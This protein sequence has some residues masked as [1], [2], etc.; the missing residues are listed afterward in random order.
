MSK[1]TIPKGT[2]DFCPIEIKERLKIKKIIKDNFKLFGYFP[3]KTPSF[4]RNSIFNKKYNEECNKL[5]FNI[6]NSGN[7]LKGKINKIYNLYKKNQKK[8]NNQNLISFFSKKALRYDLTVPLI[9]Y[10]ITHKN[11]IFFPFKRYQIQPVWRAE[12]PQKGRYR[13][14]YQ[15]DADIIGKKSLFQEIEL[16]Y[17]CDKILKELNFPIIFQINHRIILHFLLNF[18]LKKLNWMEFAL[19]LDKKNKIG[20]KGIKEEMIKKGI[21]KKKINKI[22]FIFFEKKK[23]KKK[24][25]NIYNILSS[26]KK[27]K[28][29]IKEL[30]FFYKNFKK[31]PLKHG[32]IKFNLALARGINYYTGIIFEIFYDLNLSY[33]LGGGGRYDKLIKIFGLKNISGIGISLGLDRIHLIMKKLN[34]FKKITPFHIQ[35][36]FINF[37]KKEAFFSIKIINFFRK[38]NISSELYPNN[39]KIKKQFKYAYKK[40]IPYVIMI[41]INEIKKKKIKIKNLNSGCEKNFYNINDIMNFIF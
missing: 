28:N 17:L 10:I 41:G 36:L 9:R 14:F 12:N 11:N 16:F 13:E 33:S 23:I 37:G 35:V 39:I 8:I 4:E 26:S 15:C 22:F 5:I 38:K 27:G 18:F 40:N 6:L 34:L 32:K 24:I 25:D 31:N 1:I 21:S 19:I 7:F 20:K 2:R 30:I 29:S 3:I